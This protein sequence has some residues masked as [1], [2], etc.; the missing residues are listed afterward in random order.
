MAISR[1]TT[2]PPVPFAGR[3]YIALVATLALG[4]WAWCAHRPHL[5]MPDAP[6][7]LPLL[8]GLAV[9]A[10]HFPLTLAPQHKTNAAVAVYFA[11][12]LIFGPMAGM[13]VTAASQLIGGGT[14]AFRRSRATGQRM[15][16]LPG[17]VFNAA[18][19]ALAV[20][21]AGVLYDALSPR[22]LPGLILSWRSLCALPLAA[23]TLYLVNSGAVATM[24]GLHRACHP[25]AIWR[26]GRPRATREAAGLLLL[27]LIMALLGHS[28]PWA[29]LLLVPL[30]FLVQRSSRETLRAIEGRREADAALNHRASHDA[31]TDLLNRTAFAAALSAALAEPG[32]AVALLF[33]DLD[34][35]KAIN[36]SLGHAAGDAALVAVAQRLR[37]ALRPGEVAARFGGDEFTLLLRHIPDADAARS[38]AAA[39]QAAVSPA[40]T[41]DARSVVPTMSAGIALGGDGADAATLL[42]RA[43]LTLHAAKA[44]GKARALVHTPALEADVARRFAD[45]ADLRRAIAADELRLRYQPIADTIT[46]DIVGFEALVRWEHPARG[47]LGPDAFVPLAEESG[48]ISMLGHWVLGEACAQLRDWRR[49]PGHAPL[50]VSINLSPRQL[51]DAD[52]VATVARA[53]AENAIPADCIVLELTER[54]TLEETESTIAA[55]EALRGLGVG[56]ALDDFGTGFSGLRNL[57]R[58]PVDHVK[59]DRSFIAGIAGDVQAREI[60]EAVIG[61]AHTLGL[62]VVAEGVETEGQR[63]ALR[64]MGCDLIQGYLLARPLTP[65]EAEGLIAAGTTGGMPECRTA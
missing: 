64:L 55:L 59:I 40:L 25:L 27:G 62:T 16:G 53:L 21:A 63:L 3:C 17:I 44:T 11:A 51:L 20:G 4:L 30:V 42:R 2:S 34:T 43:D 56:L 33:L 6:A 28:A 36:D 22:D 49:H 10:Q 18:Q 41:L 8:V 15:R 9:A 12:L 19:L 5:A 1:P 57:H 54:V 38:R 60:V 29:P 65:A 47:L 23:A 37:A 24:V 13:A 52:L 32:A 58:L 26:D 50:R 61:L 46:G 45:V 7:L 14:L 35:F 39:V 31:L 48:L